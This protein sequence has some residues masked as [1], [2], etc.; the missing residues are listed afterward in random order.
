VKDNRSRPQPEVVAT[1]VVPRAR[2]SSGQENFPVAS[3]LLARE[4]RP[5]VMAFYAFVR[6]ADDI[7]DDPE[8]SA[9]LKLAHLDRLERALVAGEGAEDWRR[10]AAVLR[11]TLDRTGVADRFARDLLEAFR[12]DARNAP[13]RDWDDL[14]DYCRYSAMPV[15]RFLMALHGEDERPGAASDAL[16]TA[17]QILN[18]LQD[19]GGDWRLLHRLYVPLRWL[20]AEGLGVDDLLAPAAGQAM[21]RVLDRVLDGVDQLLAV[22]RPL[23]RLMRDRRLGMEAAAIARLALA[24]SDELRRRDPLAERV[25]LSRPRFLAVAAAGALSGLVGR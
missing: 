25:E 9:D 6:L 22:A 2:K 13:C 19:C 4:R 24:L 20:E 1:T 11:R 14:I 18:H 23:G 16:C 10:P 8:L 5:Q 7:A 21:R 15:G 17:L 3:W 12:R